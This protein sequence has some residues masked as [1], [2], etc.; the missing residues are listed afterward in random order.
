M[1]NSLA[2]AAAY[3]RDAATAAFINPDDA[4]IVGVPSD[5]ED[6]PDELDD[7]DAQPQAPNE[8]LRFCVDATSCKEFQARA[9]PDGGW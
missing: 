2:E 9:R 3:V 6:G 5:D 4:A 1:L 7:A 8:A